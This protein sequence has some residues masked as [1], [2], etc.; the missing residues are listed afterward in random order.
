[1]KYHETKNYPIDAFA[2]SCLNKKIQ[3]NFVGRADDATK[4]NL[5]DIYLIKTQCI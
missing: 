4:Q 5:K 1:M 2:K 3:L